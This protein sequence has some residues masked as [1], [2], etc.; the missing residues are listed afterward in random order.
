MS[1]RRVNKN[2]NKNKNMKSENTKVD[3]ITPSVQN[4]VDKSS[5]IWITNVSELTNDITTHYDTINETLKK[6][7]KIISR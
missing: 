6:F 7:I 2:K 1:R 5:V 4:G 3:K